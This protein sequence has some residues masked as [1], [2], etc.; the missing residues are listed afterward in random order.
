VTGR[1]VP[2]RDAEREPARAALEIGAGERCVLVFGGSLG[3]RS[4]NQAAIA[5]FAD[6]PYRVLHVA[7]RRDFGHLR[8]PGPH[9]DLRDYL[10]P[11]GQAL[12][13]AD[14]AV[15]RA[16]GSVFEL[17]QYG[18]P[19]VLVPYP[20]AT[21]DHQTANA[22]WMEQ[23]GAAVTI[24]D[25]ELTPERL[26]TEVDAILLDPERLS[27]MAAASARLARPEAAREVAHA[28]LSAVR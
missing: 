25:A 1:P 23:G 4:V 18:L 5:A 28:V 19:A 11:F 6:A 15:A 24:P 14:L 27:A 21:A 2:P 7:G 9:Y 26:R 20:H 17:A 22:R 12:V 16:G 13:A 8:A 3:A 10:S